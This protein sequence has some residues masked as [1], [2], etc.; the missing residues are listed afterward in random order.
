MSVAALRQGIDVVGGEAERGVV[1]RKRGD[2]ILLLIA[3]AGPADIGV[4]VHR[5]ELDGTVV[6]VEGAVDLAARDECAGAIEEGK[7]PAGVERDRTVI[8]RDGAVEI[9]SNRIEIATRHVDGCA[10][11]ISELAPA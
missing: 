9:T 1:V 11:R 6:I 5:V 8:V 3:N 4:C 2:K 7:G 10:F